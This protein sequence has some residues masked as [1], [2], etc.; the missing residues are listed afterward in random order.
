MY[1]WW[2]GWLAPF[3]FNTIILCIAPGLSDRRSFQFQ[4][5]FCLGRNKTFSITCDAREDVII[6]WRS[7]T[8]IVVSGH[9]SWGRRKAEC[10]FNKK[11]PM[12]LCL[13]VLFHVVVNIII[14][15]FFFVRVSILCQLFTAY[16]VSSYS[17]C[18]PLPSRS[19]AR[20]QQQKYFI[21]RMRP[22]SNLLGK[23]DVYACLRGAPRPPGSCSSCVL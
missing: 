15:I 8:D 11:E 18:D 6:E 20:P 9:R 22:S 10:V 1:V 13:S 21:V 5:L 19:R 23:V 2:F 14:I 17:A 16:L 3:Q 7:L 12:Q 4:S